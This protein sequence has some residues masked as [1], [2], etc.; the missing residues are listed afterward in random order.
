MKTVSIAVENLCVPCHAACRYCL[1]DSC[2]KATGTSYDKGKAFADR[3]LAELK[4]KR[5]DLNGI[6]YIGYCMDTPNLQDYIRFCRRTGSPS[7]TFPQFNG[8][9]FR[10]EAETMDLLQMVQVEGVE[11]I[12]LTFYGTREYHDRFAGRAGDFDFCLRILAAANQIGLDVTVSVPLLRENMDQMDQLMDVLSAYRVKTVACFLP[13]SKGRG[14]RL[15]DQRL[16]KAEFEQLSDRVKAHFTKLKHQTEG[17]WIRENIWPEATKRTLTLCLT[18][19]NI[20]EL[21]WMPAEEIVR[22]LEELDDRY[23]EQMPPLEELALRYGDRD[24]ACLFRLRDLHLKWQQMYLRDHP[25][26]YDMNNE[27]HH[28]SVRV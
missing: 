3:F 20:G 23:Y 10:E 16:T 14:I 6:Y 4:E 22:M 12:D 2:K 27:G 26:L 1:L 21:E 8:F 25:D 24:G 9:A 13:H 19:E 11:N 5:P 7:A 15:A 17:E 28:F 18:P